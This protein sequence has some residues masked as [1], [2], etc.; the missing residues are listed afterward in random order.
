[1]SDVQQIKRIQ[2]IQQMYCQV[3][4]LISLICRLSDRIE[5]EYDYPY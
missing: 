1:M 2:Q 3:I 4:C 5:S